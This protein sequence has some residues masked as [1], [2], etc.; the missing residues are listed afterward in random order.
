M[1][2]ISVHIQLF[3]EAL[4]TTTHLQQTFFENV[5]QAVLMQYIIFNVSL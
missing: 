3:Y 4:L 2:A 5:K 1:Q